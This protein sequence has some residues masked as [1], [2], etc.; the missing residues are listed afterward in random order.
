[1]DKKRCVIFLLILLATLLF[2]KFPKYTF[3]QDNATSESSDSFLFKSGIS[4]STQVTTS[5]P[6]D[7][8]EDGM[9]NEFEKKYGL[10]PGSPLDSVL[11]YDLDGLTNLQEYNIGSNPISV[12]SDFGFMFD[13]DEVNNFKNWRDPRD[14][15]DL[16]PS[17]IIEMYS[18][19]DT[20]KDLIKDF[21]EFY[22]Y[23]TNPF[24]K[25]SDKDGLS[26]YIEIFQYST[27]PNNKDTDFDRLSDDIEINLY[28][29][30]PLAWDSDN[31]GDPDGDE[32]FNKTNPLVPGDDSGLDWR[33][34]LGEEY[35]FGVSGSKVNKIDTVTGIDLTME[36]TR[37]INTAHILIELDGRTNYI[38]KKNQDKIR[39]EIPEE[40]GLYIMTIQIPT[41]SDETNYT[42]ISRFVEVKPMG[43]IYRK[44][45][46][47]FGDIYNKIISINYVPWA[48]IEIQKY[49]TESNKSVRYISSY[50]NQQSPVYSDEIGTYAVLLDPG[51]YKI[52]FT[53][54]LLKEDEV[55]LNI[56]EP[57][58]FSN[59]IIMKQNLDYFTWAGIFTLIYIFVWW[60]ISQIKYQI[61]QYRLSIPFK[62]IKVHSNKSEHH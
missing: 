10:D 44:Q 4:G 55:I 51:L 15:N 47:T 36:I 13:M 30:N 53:K 38:V 9:S 24:S 49:N 45:E 57:T 21:D 19:Q 33:L 17:P 61:F 40:P 52:N 48:K 11:D 18:N 1:M 46:G 54:T 6:V 16:S 27:D 60:L 34:Y 29:T 2:F 50:F 43:K 58:I 5:V 8:D 37:P 12:D 59:N 3:S 31:G 7:I 28:L 41:N 56:T 22:T 14:D 62:L 39:F 26:D 32:I 42:R 35:H 25:D 23:Q 20:D